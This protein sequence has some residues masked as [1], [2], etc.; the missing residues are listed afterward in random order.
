MEDKNITFEDLPK[1]MSWMMDK[2]NKLDS[3]IDSLNNIPQVR[4]ADQ[5]MNLKELCE[6]LPSHPAEQ[7]VYGWT[8]C[9]QIPFHK[10]G[11]RIMFLKS[12]IDAWLRDGKVK[13]E[14][15]LENEAA[16]FIKSKRNNR[17]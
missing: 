9:H 17:F 5:W 3:K 2:L 16:R 1:A 10:R 15:D 7:T 4:P 6:Y 11:K 13:S 14:K 12:E 8:S